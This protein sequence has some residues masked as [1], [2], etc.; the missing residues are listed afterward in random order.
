[1]KLLFLADSKIIDNKKKQLEIKPNQILELFKQ[2][3]KFI[4]NYLMNL[5]LIKSKTILKSEPFNESKN[6]YI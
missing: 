6:Q 2:Y 5:I 3:R 4:L 1:M